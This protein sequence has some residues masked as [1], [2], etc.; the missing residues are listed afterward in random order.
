MTDVKPVVVPRK[1]DAVVSRLS[2]TMLSSELSLTSTPL[3]RYFEK[4]G[5]FF[6]GVERF[7]RSCSGISFFGFMLFKESIMFSGMYV[8]YV[9]PIG[10]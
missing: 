8:L 5:M 1:D 7:A 3:L 2:E 9:N 10:M 4:T 6:S